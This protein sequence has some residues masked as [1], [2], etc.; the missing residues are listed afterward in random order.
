MIEFLQTYIST[1]DFWEI[2]AL[3]GTI[4]GLIVMYL[5]IKQYMSLWYF[6]II[7]AIA[8]CIGFFHSEIY[9][10]A[11][12]QIYYIITSIYGIYS[13]HKAKDDNN[14]VPILSLR[15]KSWLFIGPFV[16]VLIGILYFFLSKT[17]SAVAI[18]D[19]VIT[20]CSAVATLMLTKK[21]IQFWLFWI[22]ADSTYVSMV[23]LTGNSELYTTTI[24]YGAYIISSIIG[25][26]QWKKD[27]DKQK[28]L[29]DK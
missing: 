6:N 23:F 13:W 4:T 17:D 27:Y 29:T 8:L 1:I 2:C 19:A 15:W 26:I 20:G 25:I 28:G 9:A 12:F 24:L 7:S 11:L 16:I 14:N 10:M 21:F 22:I 5:Q 18:P 3:I